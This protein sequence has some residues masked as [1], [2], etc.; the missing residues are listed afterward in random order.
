M[1][2]A[3][4]ADLETPFSSLFNTWRFVY[5]NHYKGLIKE[6]VLTFV[7]WLSNRLISQNLVG[8][9]QEDKKGLRPAMVFLMNNANRFRISDFLHCLQPTHQLFGE[10]M[11]VLH[12]DKFDELLSR[13]LESIHENETLSAQNKQELSQL[14]QMKTQHDMLVDQDKRTIQVCQD[15]LQTKA[16]DLHDTAKTLKEFEARLN[17]FQAELNEKQRSLASKATTVNPNDFAHILHSIN[18]KIDNSSAAP[19]GFPPVPVHKDQ[20]SSIRKGIRSDPPV[21]SAKIHLSLRTYG[22][23]EFRM[24]ARRE[25]LSNRESTLFFYLAFREKRIHRNHVD[26]IAQDED[27]NPN[28]ETVDLLITEIVKQLKYSDEESERLQTRFNS[29]RI[30]KAK[31]R[32]EEEFEKLYEI[33]QIGW[34]F[35]EADSNIAATKKKFIL[36]LDLNNKVHTVLWHE[37]RSSEWQDAATFFQ[38]TSYLSEIQHRHS[39]TP[40]SLDPT[41]PTN[42]PEAMQCNN[43][44]LGKCDEHNSSA[45]NAAQNKSVNNVGERRCKNDSCGVKFSPSNPKFVCCS[46]DCN[47]KYKE[48]KYGDNARPT[49]SSANNADSRKRNDK[50]KTKTKRRTMNNM[51]H[52]NSAS[53]SEVSKKFKRFYITPAHIFQDDVPTTIVDN[54]LFDTGAGPTLVTVNMVNKMKQL[55]KIDRSNEAPILAGDS[56]PMEGF[57]GKIRLKMSLEDSIGVL[58]NTF[59]IDALVYKELNHDLIVGQDSMLLGLNNFTC[60]P[61][62][63]VILFNATSRMYKKFNSNH[64]DK[65]RVLNNIRQRVHPQELIEKV[66]DLNETF[67]QTQI[68]IKPS[69][70]PIQT[71]TP[72]P[73][74]STPTPPSNGP[75]FNVK[76]TQFDD[77][78]SF[79]LTIPGAIF[80]EKVFNK[81]NP[82]VQNITSSFMEAME[83]AEEKETALSKILTEG[84]LD[85]FIDN[86]PI[87][88]T[89]SKLLK[90]KKGDVKVGSQLSDSTSKLL[91]DYINNFAGEVFNT[92]TLGK[93]KHTCDPEMKPDLKAVSSPPRYMPLNEYMQGEARLLVQK[94]VDLGVLVKSTKPANSTIFIVQKASGKWR[95]ICDLRKFNDRLSDFVVHLPSPFELINKI[96]KF[97]LFSYVDF[98]DAYFTMPMSEHSMK[99]NPVVASVSGMQYNYQYVRMPQGLKPA[100]AFFINMLNEIYA[101]IHEFVCNYL[102]DSVIGSEDN[103]EVHF[104]QLKKFVQ[105]TSDSGLKLS[106][107]KSCFFTKNIQFLNYT[108]SNNAWS[109]SENQRNTINALN[110][111]NLTQTKRESLAAFI[112]HFSRFHTGVSFAA[113]K[114]RDSK[115]SVSTV[116]SI[117]DNIKNK[118]ITAPALRSANFKEDLLIFTDASDLDCSG[119]VFQKSK[120]GGLHLVTCFSRKLPNS[121]L[122]KNI[123]EKELWC[124]QQIC[125]TFRYLFLGPHRKT[126]FNDN[127]AVVAAQNSRAPSLNCLFDYIKSTFTNV[128]FKHIPTG[129][130][131]SDIFTRQ[132]LKG[133]SVNNARVLRPRQTVDQGLKDKI[134]KLHVNMGC[135][136]AKRL[137]N[138]IQTLPDYKFIKIK[139]V[140]EVVGGCKTC[141]LVQNHLKPRK[142]VP[143]MTLAHE[144]CC[145]DILYIDHKE[146][147]NS[148]RKR[149]I[150]ARRLNADPD[151]IPDDDNDKKVS[152]LT[153]FEPVSSLTWFQKV[154][155]YEVDPVKSALRSYFMQ[156]GAPKVVVADNA[157]SFTALAD[158][159]LESFGARL[160]NTSAYH[161]NA[162]LAERCH[163][164]FER[165]ISKY[166]SYKK[167]YKF[168]DWENNLAMAVHSSN[169]MR[170]EVHKLSPFEIYKNRTMIDIAPVR[171]ATVGCEHRVLNEKTSSKMDKVFKSKLKVVLP[172]FSKNQVV[173]VAFPGKPIRFGKV[174]STRDSA[175]KENIRVSFNSQ[176]AVGVHKDHVC[177]P[178]S[179]PSSPDAPLITTLPT[180]TMSD[181]IENTVDENEVPIQIPDEFFGGEQ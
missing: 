55:G 7:D 65:I 27:G 31:N 1:Q 156:H 16:N 6:S 17:H 29:I 94:M 47:K 21:Y 137:F 164:E 38:I 125:K 43:C 158:W 20:F 26:Q 93:T 119:L 14:H 127:K 67:S 166:D 149:K 172:V 41:S 13:A 46:I 62:L 11:L 171:F 15:E 37:R 60:W 8:A 103:E 124:L 83:I 69:S 28:F 72:A 74:T 101:P 109:I 2:Y 161:P 75:V 131:A 118:L 80:Q 107:A 155:S 18:S 175:Q 49:P 163:L 173:K 117:L 5:E 134:M 48:V 143:G 97:S 68:G 42:A 100:T 77:T 58:T 54:S 81:L 32:L 167:E 64:R 34:P 120:S 59:E 144:T 169:S 82:T 181:D 33:R 39:N 76:K 108:V 36:T 170:H 40:V 86:N 22:K 10:I 139:D 133:L 168:E 85:E 176:K 130:N 136:P 140:E 111:D 51:G 24:W 71:A 115:T 177:V 66:I 99:H 142:S 63:D 129:K 132:A 154:D 98:P 152:V 102:D 3:Q 180:D 84:G 122:K 178:R 174:T 23:R 146:I 92:D 88:V 147:L 12:K 113:R 162:N 157:P 148:L 53:N 9:A 160:C 95:L 19:S 73:Q 44:Y 45:A 138:T 56:S 87:K 153:V 165:V 151:Y 70:F 106:L 57:L 150:T 110:T 116:D 61:G 30:I 112:T 4:P 121:M 128:I 50:S 25:T 79:Y 159:L 91:I 96:C 114:I 135:V 141:A 89:N 105:I 126:F 123:Y 52:A 78:E 179:S 90:T 104:K 145:N 35:E